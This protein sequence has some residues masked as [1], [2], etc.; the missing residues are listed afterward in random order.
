MHVLVNDSAMSNAEIQS[1][2]N[3][4]EERGI[5]ITVFNS[6]DEVGVQLHSFGDIASVQ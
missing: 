2:L 4:A 1:A 6:E 5:K 3:L